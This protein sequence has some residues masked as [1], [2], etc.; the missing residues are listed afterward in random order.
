MGLAA[1]CSERQRLA[2]REREKLSSHESIFAA[3]LA[4]STPSASALR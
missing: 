2:Q 3:C 4:K 1:P